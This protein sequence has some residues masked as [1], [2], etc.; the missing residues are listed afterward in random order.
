MNIML[1]DITISIVRYAYDSDSFTQCK[2]IYLA[3]MYEPKTKSANFVKR[4]Q[5][6]FEY[7]SL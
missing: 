4:I 2:T 6:C 1:I 7:N 3:R 5:T